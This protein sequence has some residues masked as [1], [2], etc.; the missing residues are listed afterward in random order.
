MAVVESGANVMVDECH[1]DLIASLVKAHKPHMILE[2]GVGSGFSSK[3]IL[4]AI[5]WNEVGELDPS[6]TK[7][8]YTLVDNWADWNGRA[9]KGIETL[10]NHPSCTFIPS[11]EINFVF[12]TR[13]KY[14]FIFSDADHWNADKWFDYVYTRLLKP[15]GILIY[16]DVC[17]VEPP[18]KEL[19]FPNLALIYERCKELSIPCKIFNKSS[20]K[21]E[22]CWRGLLVI[23]KP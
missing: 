8:R 3:K 5:D 4:E 13:D 6:Y 9:P 18:V 12:G 22:R 23:F 19:T 2:L 17:I 15:G 10:A 7:A 21:E 16:H 11:N 20:R 14:D 1:G